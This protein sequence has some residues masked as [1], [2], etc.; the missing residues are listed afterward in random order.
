[1]CPRKRKKFHRPG[2]IL[3][4]NCRAIRINQANAL[5]AA[6]KQVLGRKIK[7]FTE[8]FA[9]LWQQTEIAGQNIGIVR[10]GTD[11]GVNRNPMYDWPVEVWRNE[12]AAT[13]RNRRTCILQETLVKLRGFLIRERRDKTRFYLSSAGRL[14]H[15][16]Q[17]RAAIKILSRSTWINNAM[18]PSHLRCRLLSFFAKSVLVA[19][20]L[21]SPNLLP[22][23]HQEKICE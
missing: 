22:W 7:A 21:P 18:I 19:S 23:L 4:G 1:M 10:F 13:N 11:R 15:Q 5:E 2:K 6:V 17:C 14:G 8:I 9:T 12:A 20:I 3:S 16:R